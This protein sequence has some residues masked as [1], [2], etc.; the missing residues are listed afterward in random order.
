MR[1]RVSKVITRLLGVKELPIVTATLHL[2]VL[3]MWR[4]HKEGD[5]LWQRDS[6]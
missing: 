5:S 3:F 1:G 6:G 4:A 2:A